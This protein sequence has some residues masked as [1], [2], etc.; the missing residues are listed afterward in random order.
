M[1]CNIDA[2]GKRLRLISGLVNCAA[3]VVLLVLA[4]FGVGPGWLWVL[5]VLLLAAGAFQ[6]FEARAGWCVLRAMGV[7]TPR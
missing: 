2:R 7:K 3:G 1:Q 5:G 4:R 6:V